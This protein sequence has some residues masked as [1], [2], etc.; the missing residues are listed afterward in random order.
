DVNDGKYISQKFLGY[1][2]HFSGDVKPGWFGWAK[3]DFLFSFVAGQAIGNYSSGGWNLAAPLSTNFTV[4][5]QCATPTPTCTGGLAA[6]N[7]IFK[8]ALNY[9]ANDG[10]SNHRGAAPRPTP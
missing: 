10:Y 6:S 7:I 8:P 9:S 3:D 5:T 4:P 1:G 2:G